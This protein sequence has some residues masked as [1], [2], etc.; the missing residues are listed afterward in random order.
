MNT[1]LPTLMLAVLVTVPAAFGAACEG[2]SAISLPA[3]TIDKA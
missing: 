3:T 2:L 1:G